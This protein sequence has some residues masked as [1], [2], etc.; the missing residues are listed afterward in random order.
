[1]NVLKG[2]SAMTKGFGRAAALAG[3]ACALVT[4]GS[5]ALAQKKSTKPASGYTQT[6]QSTAKPDSI[7]VQE[8]TKYTS[9]GAKH[10]AL[11]EF[12]GD[13]TTKTR[14]WERPDAKPVEF[15]G[16]AEYKMILGGRFL[17]LES[18]AVMNGAE[19]HGLGIYGYDAFK[20]KYSFYYVHD[21][22]TQALYG[23]GDRDSTG[24]AITFALAMDMPMSGEHARPIRAVLRRVSPSHH[25]FE[26]YEKYIDD[27]DWK[28]LE[29]TFDRA[30]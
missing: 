26:M 4:I 1:M 28:V 20:E 6:G 8:M 29:I 10:Q 16:G 14:V 21:G 30:Q 3:A 2:G 22:E 23:L 13:W 17:E 9:P 7:V 11:A 27:R 19:T 24:S 12:A 25:T 15:A 18:R 5:S